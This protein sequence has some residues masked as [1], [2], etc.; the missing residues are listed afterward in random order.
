VRFIKGAQVTLTPLPQAGRSFV[1]WTGACS[2][3]DSCTILMDDKKGVG[4]MF[5]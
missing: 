5:Q 1:G 2:G 4:A 3:N